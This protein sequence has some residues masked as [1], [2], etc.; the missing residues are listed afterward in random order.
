[1]ARKKKKTELQ[2][3]CQSLRVNRIELLDEQGS[4]RALIS[5]SPLSG[6]PCISLFDADVDGYKTSHGI[7]LSLG[8][9]GQASIGIAGKDV[10][11]V[12]MDASPRG[13]RSIYVLDDQGRD[14]FAAGIDMNGIHYVK[15]LAADGS[16]V[17]EVTDRK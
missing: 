3:E 7:S 5:V 8:S 11:I 2:I 1:M 4:P 16:T 6:N 15:L 17:W 10:L 14:V 9:D 12:G 13:H